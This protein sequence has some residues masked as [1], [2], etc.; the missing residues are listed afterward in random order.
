[1]FMVSTTDRGIGVKE[2][3]ARDDVEADAPSRSAKRGVDVVALV[4]GLDRQIAESGTRTRM[5]GDLS[6]P[7][8]R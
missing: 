3:V 8:W 4:G 7:R 2:G 5:D 6:T 1:M